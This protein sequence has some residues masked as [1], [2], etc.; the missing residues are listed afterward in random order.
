MDLGLAVEL[1]Q[2]LH[3]EH[4]RL[5]VVGMSVQSLTQ[6]ID[7][8]LGLPVLHEQLGEREENPGAGFQGENFLIPFN[9][10]H[11]GGFSARLVLLIREYV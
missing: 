3:Q 4:A 10:L 7:R 5:K 1:G 11:I 8:V 9:F 6:R 2:Q